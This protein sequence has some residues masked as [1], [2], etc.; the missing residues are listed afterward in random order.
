MHR[1]ERLKL[2]YA[3]PDPERREGLHRLWLLLAQH[4]YRT[5]IR[6]LS[7]SKQSKFFAALAKN[8]SIAC[9]G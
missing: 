8:F 3:V 4:R 9:F 1:R 5:V 6:Y 2:R 7:K